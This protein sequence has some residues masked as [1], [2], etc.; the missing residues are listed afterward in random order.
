MPGL[1]IASGGGL[2]KTLLLSGTLDWDALRISTGGKNFLMIAIGGGGG[3]EG[4]AGLS[5]GFAGGDTDFPSASPV[6]SA[7]G[8]SGGGSGGTVGFFINEVSGASDIN[9]HSSG[10]ILFGTGGQAYTGGF[11]TGNYGEIKEME[12]LNPIGSSVAF[13]IGAGGLVDQGGSGNIANVGIQG[14]IFIHKIR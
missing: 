11:Q 7:K 3:G 8:G 6:L 10:G 9:A 4:G 14:A 12:F 5:E 13:I 1:S 2:V